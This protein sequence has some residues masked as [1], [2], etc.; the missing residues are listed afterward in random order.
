M[1]EIRRYL[2]V[3]VDIYTSSVEEIDL[4]DF[5]CPQCNGN[6]RFTDNYSEIPT[7]CRKCKGS[8]VLKAKI[9][10]EWEAQD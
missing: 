3:G 5:V 7:P 4:N 2:G 6:G 9:T 1:S 8:G 10:I